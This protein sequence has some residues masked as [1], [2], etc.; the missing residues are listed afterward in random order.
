VGAEINH[1]I[2]MRQ[3]RQIISLIDLADELQ[4]SMLRNAGDEG[5]A[6]S[7]VGAGNDNSGHKLTGDQAPLR[8][9]QMARIDFDPSLFQ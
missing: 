9:V 7:A 8:A 4:S 2:S 1:D 3:N 5:L 6:H